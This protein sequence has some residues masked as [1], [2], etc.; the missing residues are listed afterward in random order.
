MRDRQTS[1][2]LGREWRITCGR[3]GKKEGSDFLGE[4]RERLLSQSLEVSA[5][6]PTYTIANGG[7]CLRYLLKRSL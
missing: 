5:S 1:S 4:A 2:E 7:R 6:R 3:K